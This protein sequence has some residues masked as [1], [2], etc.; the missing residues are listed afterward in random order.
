MDASLA[1]V[2]VNAAL[3]D[4]VAAASESSAKPD[5]TVALVAAAPAEV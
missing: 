5:A 3:E 1:A 2:A 4:T